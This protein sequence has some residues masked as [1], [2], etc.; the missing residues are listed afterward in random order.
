[1]YTEQLPDLEE[2]KRHQVVEAAPELAAPPPMLA[3][4]FATPGAGVAGM[5]RKLA[6]LMRVRQACPHSRLALS[7]RARYQLAA[8]CCLRTCRLTRAQSLSPLA[9]LVA[10]ARAMPAYWRMAW[11]RWHCCA[12]ALG[13]RA[14]P[15][16][17]MPAGCR[18]ATG[19]TI[20]MPH[21]Q[22]AL[23]RS[24]AAVQ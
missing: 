1:V 20:H 19:P 5:H 3:Q 24:Q 22:G 9:V 2:W 11:C 23:A 8:R 7:L 17:A 10:A 15:V 16:I 13:C 6:V 4:P 18:S 21:P 12:P 14:A